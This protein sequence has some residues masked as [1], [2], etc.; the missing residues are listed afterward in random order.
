MIPVMREVKA[1]PAGEVLLVK[2]R[3]EPQPFYDVWTKMGG[4]EWFAEQ[5]RGDEWRIWVRRL[6]G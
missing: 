5:I 6:P 1:L 2:H 4:L 3:W